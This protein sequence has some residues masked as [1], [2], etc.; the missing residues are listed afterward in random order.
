MSINTEDIEVIAATIGYP[1]ESGYYN[2]FNMCVYHAIN[3]WSRHKPIRDAGNGV[4]WPAGSSGRYGLDLS[5]NWAYL[6]PRGGSPG[7][8]I[9]EPARPSDFRGYEHVVSAATKC[10]PFIHVLTSEFENE[11]LYPYGGGNS[12]NSSIIRAYR[13]NADNEN[14]IIPSQ[15]TPNLDNYYY[16]LKYTIGGVSWYKT[17]G[18]VSSLNTTGVNI[19]FNATLVESSPGA[20]DW[21]YLDLPA[22]VGS[23]LGQ[24]IICDTQKSSWSTTPPANVYLLPS[25]T[26]NGI[27]FSNGGTFTVNNWAIASRGTY[28]WDGVTEETVDIT[29]RTTSGTQWGYVAP[30]WITVDIGIYI[31]GTW[32]SLLSTPSLWGDNVIIRLTPSPAISSQRTG[33]LNIQVGGVTL[34]NVSLTQNQAQALPT[35][36]VVTSGFSAS[37]K[38]ATVTYGLTALTYGF[39]PD[40]FYNVTI[41][42]WKNGSLMSGTTFNDTLEESTQYSGSYTLPAAAGYNEVY[43]VKVV[44][45]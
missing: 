10:M 11:A 32:E 38:T 12:A 44:V 3:K 42:L 26:F 6:Q 13:T 25:G 37:S 23:A 29:I 5:D 45:S 35:A 43:E 1:K 21:H 15:M 7:G 9:D 41:S 20:N 14:G 33:T 18:L 34:F 17:Y 2:I 27:S 36:T 19:S 28:T 40:G 31:M 16:G 22:G 24:F 30:S 8:A 4:N 39:V